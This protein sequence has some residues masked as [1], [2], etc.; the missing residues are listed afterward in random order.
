MPMDDEPA[1]K[2]QK[3]EDM[4]PALSNYW[5]AVCAELWTMKNTRRAEKIRDN[6]FYL[7]KTLHDESEETP[8]WALWNF[9]HD[10]DDNS[11]SGATGSGYGSA[12]A[13]KWRAPMTELDLSGG[14]TAV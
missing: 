11:N 5:D 13:S 6:L 7:W 9:Y 2:R 3:V 1:L 8:A 10:D 4:K 14:P 12:L